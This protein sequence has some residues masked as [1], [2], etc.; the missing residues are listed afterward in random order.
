LLPCSHSGEYRPYTQRFSAFNHYISQLGLSYT[1]FEFSEFSVSNPTGQGAQIKVSIEIG[2]TNMGSK[3]GSKVVRMTKTAGLQH[4]SSTLVHSTRQR[5]LNQEIRLSQYDTL[6]SPQYLT[7][8]SRRKDGEPTKG[9]TWYWQE[10][11]VTTSLKV[12]RCSW[13]SHLKL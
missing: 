8:T 1:T 4:P 3:T 11:R 13:K 9:C 5:V 12:R 7:G 6:T 10:L 2:V